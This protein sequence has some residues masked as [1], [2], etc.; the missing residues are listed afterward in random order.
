MAGPTNLK[1]ASSKWDRVVCMFEKVLWGFWHMLFPKIAFQKFER[2][3]CCA[4]G[5]GW[6]IW[7]ILMK[8]VLWHSHSLSC[9]YNV[10]CYITLQNQLHMFIFSF[11]HIF[12]CSNSL[13]KQCINFWPIVSARVDRMNNIKDWTACTD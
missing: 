4:K 13:T 7:I 10:Y 2:L 5:K 1:W 9:T 6:L 8:L 11:L 12:S 3:C